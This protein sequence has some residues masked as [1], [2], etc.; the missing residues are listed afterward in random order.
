VPIKTFVAV[1]ALESGARVALVAPAGP[2]QRPEDLPRAEENVR[3]MGWEAVIGNHVNARMSYLAGSD[4]QRLSDL[5]RALADPK[6]D[7]VWCLRGGYGMTR[8][9]EDIDYAALSRSPKT[10]IGYSDVTALHAAIGI[11]CGLTTFHGPTARELLTDF[12]RASFDAAIV[13]RRD[14]GGSAPAA[15]ELRA[16]KATGRLAGGNLSV[17][18]ALAGTPFAPDLRDTIVILEDIN[19]PVYRVDRMLQQL[20]QSGMLAGCSAIVFGDCTRCPEDASGGGR[21]LDEVLTE[22]AAWLGVPCIAGVPIGHIDDQW[23]LPLG[24]L[25]ELDSDSRTLTVTS[26]N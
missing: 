13:Q 18:T 15:R 9:L 5:N 12:S 3:S 23:T 21:S 2:L 24:A 25:A 20:R 17:L 10:I 6:I 14:S 7:A 1:P 26:F 22:I 16:G 19:E 8:L 11:R 4:T